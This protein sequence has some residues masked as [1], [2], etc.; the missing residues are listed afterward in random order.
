MKDSTRYGLRSMISTLDDEIKLRYKDSDYY[1]SRIVQS[2][3]C[4][5]QPVLGWGF[6]SF[7]PGLKQPGALRRNRFAAK[8]NGHKAQV[9]STKHKA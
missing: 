9:L 2:Y 3:Q 6:F 4:R 1:L 8:A 5:T 7:G